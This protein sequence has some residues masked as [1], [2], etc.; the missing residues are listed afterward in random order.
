[1]QHL[2][3]LIDDFSDKHTNIAKLLLNKKF[4]SFVE[5]VPL[6]ITKIIDCM[7]SLRQVIVQEEK[8]LKLKESERYSY[9]K[10]DFEIKLTPAEIRDF[11]EKD[12]EVIEISDKIKNYINAIELLTDM[13]KNLDSSRY[14]VKNWVELQKLKAEWGVV[15]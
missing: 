14:D 10:L 13:K 11:I 4:D 7:H 8:K 15:S 9:Y 6:F 12:A 5:A 2:K 3:N 1:V